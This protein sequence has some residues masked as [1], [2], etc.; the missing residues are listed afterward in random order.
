MDTPSVYIFYDNGLHRTMVLLVMYRLHG[1]EVSRNFLGLW[2]ERLFLPAAWSKKG[3]TA[4]ND[5]LGDTAMNDE[6]E[7]RAVSAS[8]PFLWPT[9]PDWLVELAPTKRNKTNKSISPTL[10]L[11]WFHSIPSK[12]INISLTPDQ[13][14]CPIFLLTTNDPKCLELATSSAPSSFAPS[15]ACRFRPLALL[16]I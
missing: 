3:D 14:P 9:C 2:N 6:K 10:F 4:M 13:L 16:A 5:Q 15:C 11:G 12:T 8:K 7:N 1:L